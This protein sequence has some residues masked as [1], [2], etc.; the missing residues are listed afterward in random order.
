[1][2][3]EG[4]DLPAPPQAPLQR[5]GTVATDKAAARVAAL[6][7]RLEDSEAEEEYPVKSGKPNYPSSPPDPSSPIIRTG[8]PPDSPSLPPYDP[9]SPVLCW[10]RE[11]DSDF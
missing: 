5:Y 6:K 1:Q 10:E 4:R 9:E 8:F 11:I 7:R 2:D 3:L